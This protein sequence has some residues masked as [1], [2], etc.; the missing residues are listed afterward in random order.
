MEQKSKNK[1]VKFKYVTLEGTVT[2]KT[3]PLDQFQALKKLSDTLS[4]AVKQLEQM[5]NLEIVEN[6]VKKD[7]NNGNIKIK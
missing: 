3:L 5:K 1:L 4:D 6:K 7:E 2:Q